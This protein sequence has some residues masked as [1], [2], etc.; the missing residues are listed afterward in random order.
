MTRWVPTESRIEHTP[1][2]RRSLTIRADDPTEILQVM[3]SETAQQLLSALC[4]EPR[5]A[6]ELAER[7][8]TSLQNTHHHL[9]RLSEAGLLEAVGTR[10]SSRG[11]AMTVYAL[12]TERLVVEIGPAS[13]QPVDDSP[14]S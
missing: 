13:Q 6:S 4:T 7:V 14:S 8:G 12:T 11:R 9:T 5:T 10:Y 2:E 3:A 1:S